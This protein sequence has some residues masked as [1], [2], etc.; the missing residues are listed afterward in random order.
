MS[1]PRYNALLDKVR[2]WANKPEVN[3]IAN[4]VIADCLSYSADECYTN[5]RIPPLE[6]TV[7]YTIETADNVGDGS[8]TNSMYNSAYTSFSMPEDLTEFVFLRTKVDNN[9]TVSSNRVFN[10]ITDRRAFF[11]IYFENQS[12]YNWMWSEGKIYCRPQLPVGTVLQIGYYRRLPALDAAYSVVPNNYIIGVADVDQVYLELGTSSDTPLYFSTA[13]TVEKCFATFTEAF[14]YNATVTTKYYI[15]REIPN[16]LRDQKERMLM[17]GALTHV[18]AFLFDDVMEKRYAVKFAG[19]I[20]SLNKEEKMR[21]ARG[22]NVHI[23]FN[24]NGM[25]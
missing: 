3:T 5:L 12:A 23:G 2:K 21:R 1:T 20:D 22:G 13:A 14:N 11:D 7:E 16:W 15:G 24:A 9:N 18:G 25:I 6:T 10:E 19:E 4:S 8:T 17:W